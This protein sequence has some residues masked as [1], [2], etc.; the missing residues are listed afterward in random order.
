MNK[1][2]NTYWEFEINFMKIVF[3]GV[4]DAGILCL[5]ALVQKGK[6]ITAVVP[7]VP[8]HP[9]HKLMLDLSNQYNIPCLFFNNSPKEEKFIDAFKKLKPDVAIVFSFDHRLPQELLN[10]PSL[11][12]INYHPSLLPDYRGGNPFFHV[13]ANNEEKTGVTLHYMNNNFDTGDIIAQW[14][15]VIAPDETMGTL[16]DR[17]NIQ[18]V[19]MVIDIVENLEKGETLERIPQPEKGNY[20]LAPIVHPEKGE[21]LINWTKD[22]AS[23]ERFVRA[24]N[25]YF[26]ALTCFRGCFIKFWNGY[27]NP[28]FKNH[29]YTPGTVLQVSREGISIVTG[30][31]LFFPTCVQIGNFVITDIRDFINRTSI[32]AGELFTD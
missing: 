11:G 5:N 8:S 26:G 4:P 20:K 17:L 2:W 13:I 30:N 19:K 31:G 16:F 18:G 24:L 32:Q 6:N 27:Y 10:I 14:E 29:G 15:T 9:A 23:I 1:K 21:T 22:A 12:F 3:W 7:P 28:D 25:P